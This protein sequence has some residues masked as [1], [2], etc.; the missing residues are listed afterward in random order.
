MLGVDLLCLA[1][2]VEAIPIGL[3]YGVTLGL[4]WG[5]KWIG[6]GNASNPQLCFCIMFRIHYSVTQSVASVRCGK[7]KHGR[8]VERRSKI[9]GANL[10]VLGAIGC[11]EYSAMMNSF[12]LCV[13]RPP[14]SADCLFIATIPPRRESLT[15]H[16]PGST[17]GGSQM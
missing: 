7:V 10:T 4:S 15:F 3:E 1:I 9:F 16:V 6:L 13:Q 5:D 17:N 8:A 12:L 14:S 11:Y 2:Y